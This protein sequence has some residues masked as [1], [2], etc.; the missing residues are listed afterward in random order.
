MSKPPIVI[1]VRRSYPQSAERVFDA[2]LDPET[3]RRFLFATKTGTVVRAE[4]DARVGGRFV[5]VDRRAA[6]DAQHYGEYHEIQRP[7]RRVF[8]FSVERSFANATRVTIEVEP[9]GAGCE[10]TLTHEVPAEFAEFEERTRGGWT[11][12]LDALAD[13]TA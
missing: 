3:A 13:A 6:G 1:V 12:M 4:L 7:R 9:R 2:W 10:L 8:M 11:T 5:I